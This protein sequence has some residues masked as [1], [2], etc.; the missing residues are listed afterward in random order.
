MPK[1]IRKTDHFIIGYNQNKPIVADLTYA[2]SKDPQ[3]IAVFCHGYKGYKDWG[4]WNLVGEA[5]AQAGIIFLKFNFSH[6]G[7]TFENPIDF[8]DLKAFGQDNFSKQMTDLSQVMAF[9]K[10]EKQPIPYVDAKNISLIGH[11]RGGGIA[12]LMAHEN[13]QVHKLITWASV[14]DFK[15]RFPQGETL[16]RWKTDGVYY[17]RNGRT[18]QEMPHDIQFFEDFEEN[19]ERFD[20]LKAVKQLEQPFLIIHGKEDETVSED[21]ALQLKQACKHAELEFID[22]AT[23]TF[24]TFQ[25]WTKAN[26]SVELKKVVDLSINFIRRR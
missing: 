6:N 17:V 1:T 15:S 16:D 22:H 13:R 10:A 20:I 25:P 7:G 9:I 3:P 18:K 21:D 5:F 2:E 11:S 8:P 14:C 24:N 23:H 4:A 12:C 19:Q 26:V